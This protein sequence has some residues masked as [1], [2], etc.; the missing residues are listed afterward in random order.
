MKNKIDIGDIFLS[1]HNGDTS[2]YLILGKLSDSKY[3][4]A[5]IKEFETQ[6]DFLF[7]KRV[8]NKFFSK[9]TYVLFEKISII[10]KNEL[11]KYIT[12][13]DMDKY[14]SILKILRGGNVYGN[15]N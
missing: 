7:H 6:Q 13:T 1:I 11:F 9:N 3:F 12:N 4:V 14:E 2:Y 15:F 10:K 5:P 8:R